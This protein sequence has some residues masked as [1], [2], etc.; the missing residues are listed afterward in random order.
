M[1]ANRFL[2][3]EPYTEI[4]PLTLQE[5]WDQSNEDK[6]ISDDL[7]LKFVRKASDKLN[8]FAKVFNDT[9]KIP[10]SRDDLYHE[11]HK[12]RDDKMTYK[13]L[14]L[15]LD[16]YSVFAGRNVLVSMTIIIITV[17]YNIMT[18]SYLL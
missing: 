2:S 7:L 14:R 17:L 9:A 11:L 16:Q 12:L 18:H 15:K 13:Q 5:L 1:P 10:S 6:I 4:E 3:F 8:W